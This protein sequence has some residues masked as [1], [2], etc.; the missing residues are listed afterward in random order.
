L[1]TWLSAHGSVLGIRYA[2][3]IH[4]HFG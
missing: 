4:R 1:S 2:N 3:E